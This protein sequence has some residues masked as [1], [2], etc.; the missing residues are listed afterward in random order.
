[1]SQVHL[2]APPG[3]GPVV[4]FDKTR[5]KGLGLAPNRSYAWCAKLNAVYVSGV[6]F[7][8]AAL[9]Y[10]VVFV[11]E[12]K[13]DAPVPVAV[14]GL[15]RDRNLMVDERGQWR[16]RAYVPAYF[17]RHPF[18]IA[19]VPAQGA[20]APRQLVCVQEDQLSAEG[21]PLLDAQGKPTAAWEP[22]GKLLEA[23]EG[24]RPATL[25]FAQRLETLGL[26]TPFDALAL[27]KDGGQ[28]LRLQGMRR[29]DEE[30]LKKLG[31][32]ELRTFLKK[33]ELRLIYAHLMSLENFGRLLDLIKP[34][35]E[36]HGH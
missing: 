3:Y 27:P 1:M 22:V 25:A 4:P 35:T 23:V 32:R 10:P 2:I 36:S 16:E 9:E 14:L 8:R 34:G 6:E 18:C 21:T 28:Q 11:R 26:L 13:H 12:P 33:G 31:A 5:H 15:T 17:R 7:T 30:K 24:A 29:V 19:E 20:E